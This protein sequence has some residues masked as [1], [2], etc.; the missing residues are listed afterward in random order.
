MILLLPEFGVGHQLVMEIN[1][2]ITNKLFLEA[3]ENINKLEKELLN[4]RKLA[5]DE[6]CHQKNMVKVRDL[7]LLLDALVEQ[8]TSIIANSLTT[9]EENSSHL[10]SAINVIDM[11]EA[12]E[13]EWQEAMNPSDAES[14]RRPRKWKELWAE[15]V[16]KSVKERISNLPFVAKEQKASWMA[17]HLLDLQQT[18][19]ED[20]KTV[21]NFT[22]KSYPGS[23]NI[24]N[25]YLKYYHQTVSSH[26][27]CI[28]Q[29]QL[30][31]NDLYA[32]LNWIIHTY[33]SGDVMNHPDLLPE[34]N[35]EELGPLLDQ[36][37]IKNIMDKYT[38]ALKLKVP[39][40]MI[41]TL[42]EDK[43]KWSESAYEP[44]IMMGCYRSHVASDICEMIASHLNESGKI[45]KD[46]KKSVLCYCLEELTNFIH[47]YQ[48]DLKVRKQSASNPLPLLVVS[49]NSYTAL[50]EFMKTL[51]Q[52]ND[53]HFEKVE[54]T[55]KNSVQELNKILSD[56]LLLQ[57]LPCFKKLMT[58]KWLT[59]SEDFNQLI[60][61]TEIYCKDFKKMKQANCQVLVSDL[62]YQFVKTYIIQMMK[63]NI[64]WKLP[65]RRVTAANKIKEELGRISKMYQEFGTTA[66]WLFPVT[67]HLFEFINA[68][69]TDLESKLIALYKDYPD[70]GEEHISALLY[71]RGISRGRKKSKLMKHFSQLEETMKEP[72][73]TSHPFLFADIK[74]GP[75]T[76][77]PS[78]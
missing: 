46:L 55:L 51:K 34:V 47:C 66:S 1:Q 4:E 59:C 36:G 57:A 78:F 61:K 14:F 3:N 12:A 7:H 45:S 2:L 39:T 70:I 28:Q 8:I 35:V 32:L 71:F 21:K 56:D 31:S 64:S 9:P 53:A 38:E 30:E 27:E 5:K 18:I 54:K 25:V 19:V 63:M 65:A 20:L 33:K 11:D 75:V 23:Y 69:D 16:T 60:R 68:N 67:Q 76:C 26:L 49:I 40:W 13:K 10:R 41:N 73:K 77:L 6:E 48:Q 17:L 72:I 62:H 29:K 15:T 42:K 58:R 74:T 24:F 52:D 22:Q 50:E 37:I 43:S 44:E